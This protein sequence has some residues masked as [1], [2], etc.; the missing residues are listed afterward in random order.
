M[1]FLVDE[2]LHTS[3][4]VVA[5][6]AGHVCDHVNFLG[7]GG[8]KDW[9]LMAKIRAEDCTLVTNNRADFVALFAKEALHSGLLIIL[10]SVTPLLQ[11]QLFLRRADAYR[12]ARLDKH[13]SGGGTDR[14]DDHLPR[15]FASYATRILGSVSV[16]Q[17][18]NFFE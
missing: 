13:S 12:H 5:H 7:L 14:H 16:C 8:Y 11:R 17:L 1:K 4:V 10:P 6:E 9:Q 2:C 18:S 3:L 15:I